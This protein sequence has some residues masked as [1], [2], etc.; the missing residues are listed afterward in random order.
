MAEFSWLNLWLSGGVVM[1]F[2]SGLLVFFS[3][4]SLWIILDRFFLLR[5][6][7][8]FCSAFERDF[9]DEIVLN[10]FYIKVKAMPPHPMGRLFILGMEEYRHIIATAMARPMGESWQG[11]LRRLIAIDL[12]RLMPTLEK[13]IGWL[14]TCS[15]SLP[16]L[17]LL[18]ALWRLLEGVRASLI[19]GSAGFDL[20][21][22]LLILLESLFL[23]FFG[24]FVS[25]PAMLGYNALALRLN[26]LHERLESFIDE[27]SHILAR[28]LN[29]RK[30]S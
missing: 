16:L 2:S 5:R 10:D 13:R 24:L 23:L 30:V 14:A 7:E 29:E 12:Y 20:G 22:S 11:Y 25:I 27:L 19:L 6:I 21:L 28:H 3:F 17:G 26:H 1:W 18:A 15:F 4:F 9:W 8:R